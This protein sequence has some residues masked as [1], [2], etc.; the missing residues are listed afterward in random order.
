MSSALPRSDSIASAHDELDEQAPSRLYHIYRKPF[1][2]HYEIKSIDDQ[3]LYYGDIS[4]WTINKPDIILHAGNSDK[5]PVV[6]VS[7]FPKFSGP[8]LL[9]LGNPDDMNA[10]YEDMTRESPLKMKYRFEMTLPSKIGDPN[11]ERRSFLWKHTRHV[12]VDDSP[13]FQ[14]AGRNYKLVDERT[15]QLMAVFTGERFSSKCGTLQIRGEYGEAFD[16]MVLVSCVSLY[17]RARRNNRSAAGG[18]GGG[19]A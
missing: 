7:K 14:F 10:Q 9:G 11:G 2:R 15:G 8:Y 4:L 13:S 18:G 1:H 3:T 5:G 17:E 12:K 19:G 6:A 16:R